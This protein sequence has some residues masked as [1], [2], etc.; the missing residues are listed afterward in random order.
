MSRVAFFGEPERVERHLSSSW[1][2]IRSDRSSGTLVP[3]AQM[4]RVACAQHDLM[5]VSLSGPIG[6]GATRIRLGLVAR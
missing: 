6:S 4:I 5:W 2:R 1:S 3:Q